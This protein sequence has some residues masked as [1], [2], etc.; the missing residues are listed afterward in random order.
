[1]VCVGGGRGRLGLF[2]VYFMGFDYLSWCKKR[3]LESP[4][5]PE[6]GMEIPEASREVW[7]WV[8][9]FQMRSAP[10]EMGRVVQ[11]GNSTNEGSCMGRA[12]DQ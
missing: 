12:I 10:E 4:P 2:G 1:M 8:L 11:V 5:T 9:S 6:F 3:F 7:V